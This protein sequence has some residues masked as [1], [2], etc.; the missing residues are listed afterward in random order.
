MLKVA[1]MVLVTAVTP[2]MRSIVLLMMN[3]EGI[4]NA[5]LPGAVPVV[6]IAN[7]SALEIAI[8]ANHLLL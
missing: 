7:P 3:A 4:Q 8:L 1:T 2:L 6:E 5:V